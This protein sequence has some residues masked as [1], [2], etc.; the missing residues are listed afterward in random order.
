MYQHLFA[1]DVKKQLL[2]IA[3]K[4]SGIAYGNSNSRFLAWNHC[5]SAFLN[6]HKKKRISNNDFH[7]L[8]LELSAYLASFGMYRKSFLLQ[9][10]YYC[11]MNA[12]KRI[13]DPKYSLLWKIK[14]KTRN[15]AKSLLFD[16]G[17]LYDEI[18]NSYGSD[19]PSDTLITKILHGTLCFFF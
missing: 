6:T 2:L 11:H 17:G 12:T 5:H 19:I 1:L 9:R 16:E 14:P 3:R 18:K 10:D 8:C 7:I 4:Y 13:M 15:K